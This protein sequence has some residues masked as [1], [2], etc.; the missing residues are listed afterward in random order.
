MHPTL[1]RTD[2]KERGW[3]EGRERTILQRQVTSEDRMS[4]RIRSQKIRTNCQS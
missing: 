2:R 1:M 3:G 4:Q